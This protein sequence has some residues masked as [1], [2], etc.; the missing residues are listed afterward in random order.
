[1]AGKGGGAWKV[2][3]ADFV[4]AMMAFFLVMWIVAQSDQA[5]H[6]IAHHFN[7]PFSRESE[8]D[9][10]A[11]QRP[12]KHP[13]PARITKEPEHEKEAGGSHSVLLTTQG[14]QRTSIGVVV[15]FADDSIELDAEALRRVKEI[16]P[17]LIGKPQKIELR[18]H[19]SRRPLPADSPFADHWHLSYQRCQAVMSELEKLGI[20][21]ERIRLSQ[22]AGN[23]PLTS[24]DEQLSAGGYARVEISLLNE[25]TGAKL[26]QPGGKSKKPKITAAVHNSPVGNDPHS[27]DHQPPHG[28]AAN[29]HAANTHAAGTHA[30]DSHGPESPGAKKPS[31]EKHGAEKHGP[32]KPSAEKHAPDSHDVKS[33]GSADHGGDSHAPDPKPTPPEHGNSPAHGH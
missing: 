12:P 16:A 33:H 15:H 21:R 2:A 13:A 24:P 5:K 8:E 7:D 31:A 26:T 4:T 17:L 27:P 9:G 29:T 23:E 6:A 1:M 3:Y 19:S 22:A 11:H 14:G 28:H 20:P 10:T 32:E 18:G 25:T 30:A